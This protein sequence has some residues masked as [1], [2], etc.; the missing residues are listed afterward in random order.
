MRAILLVN[1]LENG[2]AVEQARALVIILKEHPTLKSLCG[3]NGNETELDMSGKMRG[4]GDAIML[5]PDIIDNGALVLLEENLMKFMQ[6]YD[7]EEELD[8]EK[9]AK[10]LKSGDTSSA[11]L[12]K[13]LE[14]DFG[15]GPEITRDNGAMTALNLASNAIGGYEEY[16]SFAMRNRFIATPEGMA[17]FCV[18]YK[19]R[20]SHPCWCQV[21]LLSLMPSRIWGR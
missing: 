2:I 19:H 13:M 8:V 21:L 9:M 1:L 15:D 3:N 20:Y 12:Y 11:E 6:Q 10:E 4:A 16:A 18:A 5:V 17:S 7:P 14:D